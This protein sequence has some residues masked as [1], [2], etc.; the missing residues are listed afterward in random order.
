M[1]DATVTLSYKM[2]TYTLGDRRLHCRDL[3]AR[4]VDLRMEAARRRRFHRAAPGA[5]DYAGS[6]PIRGYGPHHYRFHVFALDVSIPEHVTTVSALLD[7]M[8]GTRWPAVC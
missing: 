7:R 1:P 8:P 5:S 2:P 3:E 4:R 6:R